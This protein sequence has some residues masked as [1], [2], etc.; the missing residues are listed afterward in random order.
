MPAALLWTRFKELHFIFVN[1]ENLRIF[2]IY[3]FTVGVV[4]A[5]DI[6]RFFRSAAIPKEAALQMPFAAATLPV[7]NGPPERTQTLRGSENLDILS[8]EIAQSKAERNYRKARK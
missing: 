1:L 3:F 7:K 5:N 6:A 4:M 8:A 2:Q